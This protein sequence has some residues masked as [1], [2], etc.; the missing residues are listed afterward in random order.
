[1]TSTSARRNCMYGVLNAGRQAFILSVPRSCAPFAERAGSNDCWRRLPS[2]STQAPGP[3]AMKIQSV[4]RTGPRGLSL[5][6]VQDQALSRP[7]LGIV[8]KV[9]YTAL[10]RIVEALLE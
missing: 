2:L 7:S 6:L 10:A 5:L 3:P 1:M 8:T 9:R 4:T